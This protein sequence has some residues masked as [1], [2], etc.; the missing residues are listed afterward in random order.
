MRE[1]ILK[2]KLMLISFGIVNEITTESRYYGKLK[3]H[4]I[5][6]FESKR[7]IYVN[8]LTKNKRNFFVPLIPNYS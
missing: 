6:L 4:N 2:I 5:R 3:K 7:K 1:L 8:Q